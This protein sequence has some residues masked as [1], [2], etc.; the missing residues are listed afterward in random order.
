MAFKDG[1]AAENKYFDQRSCGKVVRIGAVA[2]LA[3]LVGDVLFLV[4]VDPLHSQCWRAIQ[5]QIGG[6]SIWQLA[7]AVGLWAAW[8]GLVAIKWDWFA[9]RSVDRLQRDERLAD[10]QDQRLAIVQRIN[11]NPLLIRDRSKRHR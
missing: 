7:P 11:I 10:N 6:A 3:T 8:I 2:C 9:R 4:L 5:K 1:P